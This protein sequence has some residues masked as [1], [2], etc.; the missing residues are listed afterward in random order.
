MTPDELAL[1]NEQITGMARAGLPLDQGLASLAKDMGRGRLRTV[2]RQLSDDLHS[3]LTLPE[4]LAKREDQ[5]PAY[6]AGL[7]R[8]GIRTG[9]LPEVLHTLTAYARSIAD[10]RST[11]IEAFIY[12]TI[13]A[14]LGV[15]LLA[16]LSFVGIPQFG[17]LFSS[18]NLKVNPV[19]QAVLWVGQYPVR[20]VVLPIIGVAILFLFARWLILRF[21]AGREA[22]TEF[23]Y[24]I[25]LVGTL[26]RSARL[27]A[28]VDLLACMVEY[29]VPLHEAFQLAGDATGDPLLRRQARSMRM[30]LEKG[31]PLGAALKNQGLLPEWVA[32]MAAAGERR[33]SLADTLREV[34]AVYRRHVN[35]RA[36]VLKNVLPA[37]LVIGVAVA[38]GVIVVIGLIAP[39]IRLLEALSL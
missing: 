18:F 39:M 26:L 22:W 36:G 23:I 30:Q 35:A 32:W 8:A 5:L 17:E 31:E 3:G 13:V 38:L 2:T 28:F 37:I 33:G 7:A 10:T 27:A 20:S 21:E 25:P 12:P 14:V 15:A 24:S 11:V 6:Y 16:G 29:A 19:T 4:A 34:A 9:R 1:L